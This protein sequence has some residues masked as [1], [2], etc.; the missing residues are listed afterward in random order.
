MS[1]LRC[2]YDVLLSLTI[3]QLN[4]LQHSRWKQRIGIAC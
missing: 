4:P 3:N 1:N 2:L